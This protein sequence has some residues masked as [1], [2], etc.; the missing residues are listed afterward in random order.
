MSVDLK[1]TDGRPGAPVSLSVALPADDRAYK[2][3]AWPETEKGRGLESWGYIGRRDCRTDF[4][5][6]QLLDKGWNFALALGVK[7][8]KPPVPHADS[9]RGCPGH[10][11]RA[12][13]TRKSATLM[14]RS[15]IRSCGKKSA[16]PTRLPKEQRKAHRMWYRTTLAVPSDMAGKRITLYFHSVSYQVDVFVGNQ[17]IGRKPMWELP[18]EVDLTGKVKPGGTN[19][20]WLG[21]TDYIAAQDPAEQAKASTA[22]TTPTVLLAPVNGFPFMKHSGIPSIPELRAYPLRR[23]V[24][25]GGGREH[26]GSAQE[27]PAPEGDRPGCQYDGSGQ[28]PDGAGRGPAKG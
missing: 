24:G 25:L 23:P 10:R 5:M 14:G 4:R 20:L 2:T 12:T 13:P 1:S 7:E 11:S 18:G 6:V 26:R 21:V 28:G 16:Y 27:G 17:F 3:V 19:T 15:W 22:G 9:R 8:L